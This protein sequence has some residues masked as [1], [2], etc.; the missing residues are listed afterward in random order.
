M[1]KYRCHHPVV[2]PERKT[3]QFFTFIVADRVGFRS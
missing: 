3:G 1:Q 2:R